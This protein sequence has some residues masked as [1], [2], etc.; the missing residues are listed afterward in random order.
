MGVSYK[1][2]LLLSSPTL[3]AIREHLN[4]FDHENYSIIPEQFK[5]IDR[6][7]NDIELLIKQHLKLNLN[8]VDSFYLAVF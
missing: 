4:I 8:N 3:S 6:S 2:L 1:T 5:I 7:K